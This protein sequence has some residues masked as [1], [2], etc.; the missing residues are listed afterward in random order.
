[1]DFFGRTRIPLWVENKVQVMDLSD[2]KN[3]IR[4]GLIK[5]ETLLINTL[6]QQKSGLADWIIPVSDSWLARFIPQ[7]QDN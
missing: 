2:L 5:S 1:M 4:E 7:P 3:Q 6:V